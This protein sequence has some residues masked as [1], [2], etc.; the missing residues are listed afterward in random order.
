MLM[1]AHNKYKISKIRYNLV[2]NVEI[3]MDRKRWKIILLNNAIFALCPLC[4][5]LAVF[6]RAL[7]EDDFLYNVHTSIKQVRWPILP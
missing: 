4:S 1:Y 7:C 2:F 3:L 6:R 5:F